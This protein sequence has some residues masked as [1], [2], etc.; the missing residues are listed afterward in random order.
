MDALDIFLN[1]HAPSSWS[2][3][4]DR[5]CD[6]DDLR[7]DTDLWDIV[8]V[9]LDDVHGFLIESIFPGDASSYLWMSPFDIVIH[10]FS[11]IMEESAL[12]SEGRICSDEFRD[13]FRDIGDFLRVHE[14]ILTIARAESEFPDE[15]EYLF[16]DSWHSHFI[17]RLASEIS[18]EPFCI[19]LILFDD[20]FYPCWLYPLIFDEF[21]ERFFRDIA[22]KEIETRDEDGIWGIIDNE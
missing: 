4:R 15:W 10:R 8:M 17:D 13:R 12:Q 2:Y 16:W 22:T 1:V 18:D 21:F 11:E 5:I 14:N 3:S 19:F 6:L 20:F 9:S 7:L